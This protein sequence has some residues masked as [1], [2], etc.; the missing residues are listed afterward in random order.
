MARGKTQIATL[1]GN[2]KALLRWYADMGVD[3]AIAEMPLDRFALSA[4]KSAAKSAHT[5]PTSTPTR[6][7]NRDNQ[8]FPA[9]SPSPRTPPASAQANLAT[10]DQLVAGASKLAAEAQS[11]DA[12]YEAL[13][14]FDGCPLK[15]TAKNLV[16]C[17]GN[18]KAKVM[19]IGE[20]PGA[21]EDRQGK[22]F[23]GR[24]GQLLDLM[25]HAIGLDRA[26][27]DP[28][29]SVFISNTIFWRPPGNRK[30][31]AAESEIC[32]PFISRAIELAAPD[33]I[34][35]LGATPMHRL[36]GGS[37]GILRSRGKWRSF[38]VNGKPIDLLPTLH[39]AYLLR[40][41]AQ[42]RLAWRDFLSLR[43]KLDD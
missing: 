17:D 42:K 20:A 15:K 8:A 39:P 14:Q 18:P 3:E 24:S 25:L 33:V 7:L 38:E 23:V 21:D 13:T 35:C 11:L 37:E 28:A 27:D 31:T 1:D 12:I 30:P 34:V 5:V 29:R 41:P 9:P 16:F 43:K 19:M 22:P 36:I 4:V 10:Q 40:Q 2:P 6:R 32:F 26:R